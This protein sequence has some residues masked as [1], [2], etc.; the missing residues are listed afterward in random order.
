MCL[1]DNDTLGRHTPVLSDTIDGC[2]PAPSMNGDVCSHSWP[3][4]GNIYEEISREEDED[5][6]V[7]GDDE[8]DDENDDDDKYV[9]DSVVVVSKQ[10]GADGRRDYV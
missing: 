3:R 4:E 5:R 7:F 10:L 1:C 8:N 9:E 2:T 6:Q